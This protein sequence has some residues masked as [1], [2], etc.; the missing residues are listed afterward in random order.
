MT[1]TMNRLTAVLLLLFVCHCAA[2]GQDFD[3]MRFAGTW[4][5]QWTNTT[6][7]SNG[8]L[9]MDIV[10]DAEADTFAATVDWGGN[11]FG[12]ADPDPYMVSGPY[13]GSGV[14]LQ[15]TSPLEGTATLSIDAA[16]NMSVTAPAV[17]NAGIDSV[18][19][20]ASFAD[21]TTLTG[22]AVIS[23][24][25]GMDANGVAT[26]DGELTGTSTA[27]EPAEQPTYLELR[28]NYPNPFASETTI[29]YVLPQPGNVRIEVLDLYGRRVAVPLDEPQAAGLHR[30]VFDAGAL[31]NGV[32]LYRL[33]A[34]K[35][36]AVR[37]MIVQK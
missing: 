18:R 6:F 17:P 28:K 5:G 16:Y 7:N 2:L 19:I 26:L 22:T 4:T 12:S 35:Y 24:T 11:V 27:I 23:L 32:Y 36:T 37:D 34:G 31:S 8:T 9:S 25:G 29:E 13:S 20:N 10:V 33:Q 15:Y 3:P 14:S 1:T 30:F 21:D